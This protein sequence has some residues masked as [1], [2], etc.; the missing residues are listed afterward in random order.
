MSQGSFGGLADFGYFNSSNKIRPGTSRQTS[1]LS[2][3]SQLE[4]IRE[5]DVIEYAVD[6]DAVF[7]IDGAENQAFE[8]AESVDHVMDQEY[9]AVTEK[10]SKGDVNT[11]EEIKDSP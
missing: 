1:R 5:T 7:D 8:Q 10:P 6:R 2:A 11:I 3:V 4:N 9:A